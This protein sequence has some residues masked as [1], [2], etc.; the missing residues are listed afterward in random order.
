M[1]VDYEAMRARAAQLMQSRAK[2]NSYTQGA[3]RTYFFGYPDN[4]VG[5]TTQ[6]GFSDC[7][8]AVAAAIRAAAGISIGSNTNAQI[9]NRA[10]GAI[11]DQ[12]DG[13]YPN[14]DNLLPGD[15]LYFKGNSGHAMDVGHVEMYI[16]G[17]KCCGHGSGTGPTIKDMRDYCRSR[18]SQSRRYFMAIRWIAGGEGS[19]AEIAGALG[20]RLLK[21]GCAGTDVRELQAQLIALGYA[22]SKYGADGEFGAETEAAVKGFQ[23]AHGLEA[24]GEYGPLTH[25]ALMEAVSAAEGETDEEEAPDAP[26]DGEPAVVITGGSVNARKG[27]ATGYGVLTIV[28]AGER[29]A[30]IATARNGWHC[31]A[32]GDGTA[33]VSNKYA[34][35]VDVEQ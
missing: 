28:H 13:Y 20:E 6:A 29:Y 4:E 11:V 15:C 22:L 14:E 18:A 21:R 19:G 26:E 17:G 5:N 30:H 32:V 23:A 25:A 34:E 33:W 10:K 12:T 1:A 7:S 24:D 3:K 27:P 31:I 9:K 35:V 2:K 16:G 8:A